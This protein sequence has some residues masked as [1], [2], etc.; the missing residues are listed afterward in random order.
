[1]EK[2]VDK[3]FASILHGF[4]LEVGFIVL[5]MTPKSSRLLGTRLPVVNMVL[6]YLVPGSLYTAVNHRV[7][8]IRHK[9]CT[10]T[11]ND[12]F[13]SQLTL[14]TVN[15]FR[16]PKPVPI[17]IPSNIIPQNGFPVVKALW[18]RHD[19]RK[20]TSKVRFCLPCRTS[21]EQ[22]IYDNAALHTCR[23]PPSVAIRTRPPPTSSSPGTPVWPALA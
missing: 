4:Y 7:L 8:T 3:Q 18:P 1:M 14:F 13:I 10:Y 11:I 6:L 17:L 5:S 20:M 16:T 2:F 23:T 12:A 19:N 22:S 21:L 9:K 15:P